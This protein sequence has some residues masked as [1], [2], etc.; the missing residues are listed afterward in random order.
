MWI[1]CALCWCLR[2]CILISL[3]YVCACEC[4][5]Y[6]CGKKGVC[7]RQVQYVNVRCVCAYNSVHLVLKVLYIT[8]VQY[9]DGALLCVL[10][11]RLCPRTSNTLCKLWYWIMVCCVVLV[12]KKETQKI[13]QHMNGMVLDNWC[14]LC[15]TFAVRLYRSYTQL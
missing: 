2:V 6:S 11:V 12:C 9:R 10:S 1:I 3:C 4:G 7:K 13:L 5:T 14:S 8:M 15:L